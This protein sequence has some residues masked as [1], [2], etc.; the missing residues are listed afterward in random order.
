MNQQDHTITTKVP[1]PGTDAVRELV[2]QRFSA[3]LLEDHLDSGLGWDTWKEKQAGVQS[4]AATCRNEERIFSRLYQE[5]Q[6]PLIHYVMKQFRFSF[7]ESEELVQDTFCKLW[8]NRHLLTRAE[9]AVH[10]LFISARNRSIDC[11]R[12]RAIRREK[13]SE[14]AVEHRE[15]TKNEDAVI[16]R[17]YLR[18]FQ[19]SMERLPP[20]TRKIFRLNVLEG[21]STKEISD[22]LGTSQQTVKNQLSMALRLVKEDLRSYRDA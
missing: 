12:S 3:A 18:C 6:L 20:R 22:Q 7:H 4:N 1:A 16:Y 17:E 11:K 2:W 19:Q 21:K 5:Y 9:N 13:F 14:L 10:Y 8:I 15:V